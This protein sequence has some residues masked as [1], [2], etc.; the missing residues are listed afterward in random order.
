MLPVGY[1]LRSGFSS[2]RTLL[3]K[4]LKLSYHELFPDQQDFAHLAKT[5]EQYFSSQTPLWWVESKLEQQKCLDPVACLWMG[6]AIDQVKGDRYSYIF[7]LYVALPH[8]RKGIGRGLM[9]QA[10][11][12][13]RNR[14]DRQIGLQVFTRDRAAIDLYRVLN[15]QVNSLLMIKSLF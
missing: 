2:D 12:L 5:V 7:L 10:E 9:Q 6:N 11:N 8:R 1:Q 15:Y 3:V 4:F 14:G 13:A